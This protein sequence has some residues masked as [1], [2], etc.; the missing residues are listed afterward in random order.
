MNSGKWKFTEPDPKGKSAAQKEREGMIFLLIA[1]VIFLA[2]GL[3]FAIKI[4]AFDLKSFWGLKREMPNYWKWRRVAAEYS[5]FFHAPWLI[6]VWMIRAAI[7]SL[8]KNRRK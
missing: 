5:T 1:G 3:F 4:G 7:K 6:G 2:G 8:W